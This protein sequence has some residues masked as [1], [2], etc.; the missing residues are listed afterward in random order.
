MAVSTLFK[1]VKD[2]KYGAIQGVYIPNVLQ[3]IGVILFMRLGWILG[4]VGMFTMG[5]II[6]LSSLLILITSLSMTSIVSNM[7]MRGGGAYYLISRSLGVEF[8]S[9][10]GVLQCITQLCCVA[11]CVSG[12]AQSICDMIPGLS[13]P[14][15]KAMTL[16][17]LALT[18]Y[19]STDLAM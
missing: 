15:V 6:T 10:V 18:S 3:M 19:F 11:L 17:V 7:K 5:F 16:T 1:I 13:E 2:G 14:L 4:H 9:A 12:F 8:G